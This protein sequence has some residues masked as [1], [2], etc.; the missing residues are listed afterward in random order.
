M[1]GHKRATINA[2][3]ENIRE[4]SQTD[5]AIRFMNAG[6]KQLS[7]RLSQS[8][9]K[10]RERET[11]AAE[12][13][14]QELVQA[15]V[16][17]D[18][19]FG[20]LEDDTRTAL[21]QQEEAYFEQLCQFGE[22]VEETNALQLEEMSA[23]YQVTV[24]ELADQHEAILDDLAEKLETVI[25]D[26]Q[27]LNHNILKWIDAASVLLNNLTDD[28]IMEGSNIGYLTY[29]ADMISQAVENQQ[30]GYQE[31]ALI[32]AQNA[33]RELSK[34]RIQVY[35]LHSQ[36]SV[37][38]STLSKELDI[39]DEE[40]NL[41]KQVQVIDLQGKPLETEIWVDD[42]VGGKLSELQNESKLTR[43][44]LDKKPSRALI[45]KLRYVL[46]NTVPQWHARLSDTVY[47][48]RS[49][50]INS[51]LRMNIALMVVK[52]LA[53]QGYRL[54]QSHYSS[55]DM[56]L[57]YQAQLM[58][59]EGSRVLVQVEAKGEQPEATELNIFTQDVDKRSPHELKQRSIEIQKS[60]RM[61]G[62]S[63]G[64]LTPVTQGSSKPQTRRSQGNRLKLPTTAG[65][66]SDEH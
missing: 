40:L 64:D 19:V 26:Q 53:I 52:A 4:L 36:Y 1:S 8:V 20:R 58:D 28:P 54:E 16:D 56:R 43:S 45:K 10:K 17:I 47:Q 21:I 33:Y 49:E 29:Y 23:Q 41:N 27:D 39:F 13:K 30:A 5:M 25:L 61:A 14:H 50:V 55:E 63:V 38:A 57:D 66:V 32:T 51:Q 15:L 9:Q 60:L 62:L 18:E 6:L 11:I 3:S 35:Q 48:A 46:K 2:R 22:L 59:S 12:N 34:Y 7:Q 24:N 44:Y 42:W 37:L 31:A 65:Q